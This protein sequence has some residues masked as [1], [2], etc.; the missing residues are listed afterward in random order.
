MVFPDFVKDTLFAARFHIIRFGSFIPRSWMNIKIGDNYYRQAF[1][2]LN[3][4]HK[5]MKLSEKEVLSSEFSEAKIKW[6]ISEYIGKIKIDD[7]W[8]P[9]IRQRLE[10][11][12]SLLLKR[13]AKRFKWF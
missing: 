9:Y 4:A 10:K 7:E 1:Q 11:Y 6:L 13:K 8:G 2:F 12:L 5:N 3:F